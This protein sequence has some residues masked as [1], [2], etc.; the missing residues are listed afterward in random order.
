MEY[1]LIFLWFV[2]KCKS[3]QNKLQSIYDIL[4]GDCRPGMDTGV[5]YHSVLPK[6]IEHILVYSGAI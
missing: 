1:R 5:I 6:T 3:S 2:G 4:D